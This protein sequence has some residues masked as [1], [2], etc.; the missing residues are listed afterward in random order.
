MVIRKEKL[1]FFTLAALLFASLCHSQNELADKGDAF[2]ITK[3]RLYTST[4]FSLNTRNAENEDQLFRQVL[5]Q[6]RYNYRIIA[7]V[8]YAIKDNIT[9][10]LSAGYGREREEITFLDENGE[11]VTTKSLEQGLSIAPNMR[12]YIPIGTGQLQVLIQ[13]ELGIT[14][15]ESLER[16]FM[17][18]EINKIEGDF[19]DMNLGVSP[20]LV[21]FFNRNWAFETTVDIAGFSIRIEEEVVNDDE[22]N[23]QRVVESDIDL[24]L[25]LLRLNLGVA[26]YF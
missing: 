18:S 19:I 17:E 25:N 7:N 16:E 21:L 4:T 26:Y 6:D 1:L 20:G 3:G 11:N 10:G 8:G 13:T 14:I 9:L 15:G 24:R 12:N 22:E 5:D 2:G 23:R